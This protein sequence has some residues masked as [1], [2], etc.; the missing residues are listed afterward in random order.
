MLLEMIKASLKGMGHVGR[1]KGMEKV[2]CVDAEV[3]KFAVIVIDS[4]DLPVALDCT[5]PCPVVG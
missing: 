2:S 1:G 4:A 3:L 5:V